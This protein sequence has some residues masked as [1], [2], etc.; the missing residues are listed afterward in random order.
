M[1][2]FKNKI[3]L[4]KLYGFLLLNTSLL[5]CLPLVL[6][7]LNGQWQY[8]TITLMPVLTL[9]LSSCGVILSI[10]FLLK[11]KIAIYCLNV[12]LIVSILSLVLFY[13]VM[14]FESTNRSLESVFLVSCVFGFFVIEAIIGILILNSVKLL[15]EFESFK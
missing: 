1:N 6:S 2:I 5:V 13:A 9:C 7:L 8:K 4:H 14:F 12:L 10:M 11:K 15:G 3:P